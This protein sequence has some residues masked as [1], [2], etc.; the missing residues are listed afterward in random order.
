MSN[1]IKRNPLQ[2]GPKQPIEKIK[3]LVNMKLEANKFNTQKIKNGSRKKTTKKSKSEEMNK[4]EET[5]ISQLQLNIR[6]LSKPWKFG[7]QSKIQKHQ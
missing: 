1:K 3:P 4:K 2:T 7:G 5:H 6:N